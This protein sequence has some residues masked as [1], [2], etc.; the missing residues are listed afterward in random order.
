MLL[1]C[2]AAEWGVEQYGE[3]C[4]RGRNP[5]FVPHQSPHSKEHQSPHSKEHQSPHSKEH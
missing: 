3:V 1:Y 2:I 5:H 4:V